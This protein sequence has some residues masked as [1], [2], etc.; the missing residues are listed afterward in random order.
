MLENN[1]KGLYKLKG[2]S[3]TPLLDST[4]IQNVAPLVAP[5]PD[6]VEQPDSGMGNLQNLASLAGSL[7]GGLPTSAGKGTI[8]GQLPG[9]EFNMGAVNMPEPGHSTPTT[10]REFDAD[11]FARMAGAFG[12]AIAPR[13]SWQ[14]R[15][16]ATASG[17]AAENLREKRD[18]PGRE[19]DR[20]LKLAQALKAERPE[21]EEIPTEWEA[22]YKENTGKKSATEIVTEF[23]K[24]K[25][26]EKDPSYVE[27]IKYN[28]K[29]KQW[30]KGWL[31]KGGTDFVTVGPATPGEV[32]KAKGETSLAPSDF[33]KMYYQEKGANPNLTRKQL[34][35]EIAEKGEL[36]I[37]ASRYEKH[38]TQYRSAKRGVG[39]FY[40]DPNKEQIANEALKSAKIVSQQY[41]D[42]GGDPKNLGIESKVAP[43]KEIIKREP[44]ETIENYLKRIGS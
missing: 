29:T 25:A 24:I 39:A 15:M 2:P 21:K 44:N 38:L 36:G 3:R 30:E 40:E 27:D 23:H 11:K 17:L 35:Q 14:A 12:A 26:A 4:R 42:A 7:S 5:I 19:L 28:S 31:E 16:G 10:S 43:G 33:D 1:Y 20:R 8:P 13:G 34:K 32:K 41:I 22:Y 37:L 18:A 9:T 6:D